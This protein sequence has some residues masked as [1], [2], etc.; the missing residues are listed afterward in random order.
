MF[1]YCEI[2]CSDSFGEHVM[3]SSTL[4]G[5]DKTSVQVVEFEL[6]IC[7]Q[8]HTTPFCTSIY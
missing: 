3:T 2:K 7:V 8:V 6:F 5:R 1:I 4:K